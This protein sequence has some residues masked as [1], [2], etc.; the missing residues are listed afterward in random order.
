MPLQPDAAPLRLVREKCLR[1][2]ER[3]MSTRLVNE[4]ERNLGIDAAHQ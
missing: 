4:L 3:L 2:G 1:P